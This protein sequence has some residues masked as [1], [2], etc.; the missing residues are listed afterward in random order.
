MRAETAAT[1]S[2]NLRLGF[3]QPLADTDQKNERLKPLLSSTCTPF[4]RSAKLV[5]LSGIGLCELM[6]P[7]QA[8]SLC[9]FR[10]LDFAP[11]Y[12]V[13]QVRRCHAMPCRGNI[14]RASH[15]SL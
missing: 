12:R 13:Q 5:Y 8:S 1:N 9:S 14:L 3:L 4:S 15:I 11:G 2:C 10:L 6:E 7:R